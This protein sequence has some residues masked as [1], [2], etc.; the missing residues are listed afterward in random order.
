[1]INNDKSYL[2]V[3]QRSILIV[4]ITL[5]RPNDSSIF[6]HCKAREKMYLVASARCPS[7][8]VHSPVWTVWATTLIL[9]VGSTLTKARLGMYYNVGQR[10]QGQMSEIVVWHHYWFALR[11]RSKVMGQGPR[12]GS[13]SQVKVKFLVCS[14]RYYGL[15]FVVC[16][17]EQQPCYQSKVFVCVCNQW[18][19]VDNCVDAVD[20][21]FFF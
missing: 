19:Y 5:P 9:V 1:M 15:R 12:S 2:L 11:S 16:S 20:R 21:L 13:K 17:K 6:I 3:L 14:S 7:V 18:A 4:S 8:C 10:T